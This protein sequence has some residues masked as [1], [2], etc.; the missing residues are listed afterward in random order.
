MALFDSYLGDVDA[1]IRS[2][3]VYEL[4]IDS[5]SAAVGQNNPGFI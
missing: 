2:Q 5:N 3:W 4:P 1:G